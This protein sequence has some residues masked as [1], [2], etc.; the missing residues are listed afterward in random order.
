MES[1]KNLSQDDLQYEIWTRENS[2]YVHCVKN[3]EERTDDACGVGLRAMK[4]KRQVL[5]TSRNL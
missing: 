4:F 2:K 5:D 3:I 1:T